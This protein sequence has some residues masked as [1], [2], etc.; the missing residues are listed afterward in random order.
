MK[1]NPATS[2]LRY[3]DELRW[4]QHFAV[5]NRQ[6]MMDR[7]IRQVRGWV[8]TP[9]VELERMNCHHNFTECEMQYGKRV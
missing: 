2:I 6:E 8:G 5:L 7:V 1:A 9:V 4:A 3:I